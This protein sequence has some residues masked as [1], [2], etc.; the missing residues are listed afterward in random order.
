M[1]ALDVQHIYFKDL[2]IVCN[3]IM[4]IYF[5]LFLKFNANYKF[6]DI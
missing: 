1:E 2:Q 5:K 4:S 3:I 6:I